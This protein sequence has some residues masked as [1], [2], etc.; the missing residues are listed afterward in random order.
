[1]DDVNGE[2][3]RNRLAGSGAELIVSY[4]FDQILSA[5]TIAAAPMGGVN[6]HAALLPRHRG[7]APT[8]HA[9]M[10]EAPEFGVTVHRLAP[11]IDAGPILA[12]ARLDLPATT[13]AV[14]AARQAHAAAEPLL[15]RVIADIEAGRA[16]ERAFEP[17]P[18]CGWPSAEALDGL[19]RRGRR[20]AGLAD[21][22]RALQTP[23]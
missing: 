7:P 9:L 15:A 10:D 20:L 3:F 21:C 14:E 18:Y 12:Q 1:V 19:A 8:I 11:A 5:A 22:L 23:T 2:A 6:V 4:H 13:T 16:E 17:G